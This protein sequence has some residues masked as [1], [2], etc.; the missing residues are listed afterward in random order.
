AGTSTIIVYAFPEDQEEI[1]RQILGGEKSQTTSLVPVGDLDP[2]N[3]ADTLAKMYGDPKNGAPFIGAQ[4]ERSAIVVKGSP[5]QVA[6]VQKTVKVLSGAGVSDLPGDTRVISLDH[7]SAAMLAEEMQRLMKAMRKNPVE[8]ITPGGKQPPPK[9]LEEKKPEAEPLKEPH[10]CGGAD[11]PQLTD[12]QKKA[13]KKDDRKDTRPGDK[14]KPLRIIAVGSR[15]MLR[16]DDPKELALAVEIANLLTRAPKGK[17]NFEIIRLKNAKAAD[18]AKVLDEAF[19]GPRENTQQPFGGRGG[20]GGPG[21]FF[22]R[23]GN[24]GVQP[25]AAPKEDTIRV[26]ADPGSNSLLVSASPLDMLTIRGLLAKA[27]DAGENENAAV[28]KTWVIGPLKYASAQEVSTVLKEVYREQTNQAPTA[29]EIGGGRGA[30]FRA[31][32]LQTRNIGPDGLP[33]SVGLS[34]GVDDRTNSLMLNCSEAVY[35]DIDRLVKIMEDGAK[36]ASRTVRVINI[37]G[38]DPAIVQQAVDAIQGRVTIRPTTGVGGIGLPSLPGIG[39]PG[40]FPGGGFPGGGFPGGGFPGGGFPGG[41]GRGGGGRGGRGFQPGGGAML[42]PPG[43]PDFFA[44]RVKDDPQPTLLYDPQLDKSA[45]HSAQQPDLTPAAPGSEAGRPGPAPAPVRPVSYEEEQQQPKDKDK[46]KDKKPGTESGIKI[47]SQTLPLPRGN[48]SFTPL[49]ELGLGVVS[50][51]NPADVEAVIAIVRALIAQGAAGNLVIKTVPLQYADATSVTNQL[52]NLYRN[53]IVG[54]SGN[55]RNLQPQQ[56]VRTQAAEVTVSQLSSVVLI[57]IPRFNSILLAAPQARVADVEK[58][59]KDL[60]KLIPP[61]AGQTEF[62]LKHASA[63]NV[64]TALTNWYAQRYPGE[65]AAQNQIRITPDDRTNRVFV[66]A[67]PADLAQIR[68]LIEILDEKESSAINELRIVLLRTAISDDLGLL[69]QRALQQGVLPSQ[70][71]GAGIVSTPAGVG[72]AVG[73]GGPGAGGLG[74]LGGGGGLGG[75]GGA[76]AGGLGGLGAGGGR[77]FGP[78]AT[79]IGGA[80][81]APG[82]VAGGA[83]IGTTTKTTTLRFVST[84]RPGEGPVESGF[85]EDI[86]ITSDPRTNSLIISAPAKTMELLLQLIRDLDVPPQARAEVNVFRLRRAD[87]ATTAG[88][89][90]QLFLGT[91]GGFPSGSITGTPGLGGTGG[92]GG[93]FPGGGGGGFPGGGGGGLGAGGLAAG[94]VRPLQLTLSGVTAEGAVL[95]ELRLTVDVRTNSLIVAGSRNDLDVIEAILTRLDDIEF[96]P[97]KSEVYRLRNSTAVDVANALNNYVTNALLVLQRGQQLTAYQDLLREVIVVP[98]PI[99]NKLLISASPR[100]F[101]EVLTLIHELDAELP[102]V[103]IQVLIAEV[104]LTTNEEFGVEIGLQSPVLFN[105]STFPAADFLTGSSTTIGAPPTGATGLLPPGATVTTNNPVAQPGFNFNQPALPLGNNPVVNP[106]IVGFQGLSSL[107][108]GRTDSAGLGG[109]VFSAGSNAFNLLVR[110]LRQQG[111]IDVL[112]RPQVTALD[113][114]FARV[115]VGQNFP[116][117]LGSNVTA[118]GVISNNIS[119]TPVGV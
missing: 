1:G 25:P 97:R 102:Q 47:E 68:G 24:P 78:G 44:D 13:E 38:I 81:G 19:N 35:K 69:L 64:A 92:A 99:T 110:A 80:G 103:V 60:D 67:A 96:V 72:G 115:F 59:I 39:G 91:T 88:M 61:A 20:F 87:A 11:E 18:A 98:E 119:Y 56:T 16:S 109:F 53:V 6:D 41:G 15:L 54:T 46:D 112:S 66:Q 63:R 79:G 3:V 21:G 57:P 32:A 10:Q 83:A 90:Q 77:G 37:Q 118:T 8:V 116:I 111:R 82:A 73:A 40:M 105:R 9:K 93:G 28:L 100:Y 58:Q 104:D 30:I 62:P 12:P 108:V 27:I 31:A 45:R 2:I 65:T 106:G 29:S 114:Q 7:G 48:V 5:A 85:L 71:G 117:I 36:G 84:R 76:G 50:G 14:E 23:F 107:G 22:G 55:T 43:G 51:P 42:T 74:G 113:N 70:A 52:L 75:L 4:P 95:V 49:T 89:L 34:I 33:R 17:G 101:E 26:V 86:H 94:Q